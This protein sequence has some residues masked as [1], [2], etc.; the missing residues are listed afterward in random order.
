[1]RFARWTGFVLSL[2]C[3]AL[4]VGADELS[5]AFALPAPEFSPVPIWWWS[6]DK[7]DEARLRE[8][9]HQLARGGIHNAIILN[10]APSGPLYGSAQDDPP[11]LT[12][13]WWKLFAAAVDE[14]KNAGVRIWFYDQ[15][16]FSGSNLQA[17]LV[18]D[19]PVYRGVNLERVIADGSGELRVEIPP[20]AE[21][22]AAFTAKIVQPEIPS[23]SWIWDKT[24]P[25]AVNSRFFRKAVDVPAGAKSLK[26][27]VTGDNGYVAWFNGVKLG[28]EC[29]YDSEGWSEAEEFDV[30]PHLRPN[31]NVLAVEGRNL[32]G[33]G[34]I[35]VEVRGV[36]AGGAEFVV[37]SDASFKMS[38][39]APEGWTSP[40]YD[41]VTW[42]SADVMGPVNMAPYGGVEGMQSNNIGPMGVQ[43]AEVKALP[44]KV[45]NG[46][47]TA[48]V[49]DG[50]NRLM[51]YYTVPGGFD[52]QNPDAG[53][54]LISVVHG[55][56][57]KRFPSELGKTIAGSFQDEFP[58]LPR[59]SRLMPEKF[60]ERCV[61][62]LIEYLPALHDEVVD[63]FGNPTGPT[64]AQIR[65]DAAR[66]AAELCEEAFFIPLNKWHE[67]FNMLCGYDQTVRNADPI[68]GERYYVDYFKT[69]RHY[70]VPGNDM[71]GDIKPHQAI[72]ELYKRP[73]VW[74]EGFHSS[75]WGQT[76]EDI[77]TILHPW[78]AW[79]ATLFNPHAIYYSIHGSYWEWAPPD[80]GWR[81]PYYIHYPLLADYSARLSAVLAKGSLITDIAV[82][83]PASTV[84][85]FTGFGEPGAPANQAQRWYWEVQDELT[86]D[87]RDFT[88]LDED[89]LEKAV[90]VKG[91]LFAGRTHVGAVILPNAVALNGKS[92]QQLNRLL[93]TGGLVIVCGDK[94]QWLADH[95]LADTEFAAALEKLMVRVVR[96]S[97][98][99]DLT[100]V[101]RDRVPRDIQEPL[102]A[103]HRSIADRDFYFV[104]S[105]DETKANGRARYD[106]NTRKLW[107]TPAAQGQRLSFTANVDGVPE[108][109]DAATGAITRLNYT[110][111]S[112]KTKVTVSLETTP[113][114]LVSFRA[115]T[116]LD[117]LAVESDLDITK[118][119]WAADAPVVHGVPP[120][121]AEAQAATSHVARIALAA[122]VYEGSAPAT[123]VSPVEIAGPF[124]SR[125]VR[126][127]DNEDGSFAWP[128]SDGLLPVEMRSFKGMEESSPAAAEAFR[129]PDFD[130]AQWPKVL[131]SFGPRASVAG[132][133]D[134]PFDAA[135]P[136]APAAD[137]F[138]PAEYSLKLGINE[139]PVFRAALGG[140][141]RIPEDFI[142]LG[143]AQPG[144]TYLVRADVRVPGDAPVNAVLRVGAIA[145]KR[146]FMNGSEVVF[147]SPEGKRTLRASVTLKPGANRLEILLQHAGNLRLFYQF[148]PEGAAPPEAEWIWSSEPDN[149]GSTRFVRTFDV[150]GEVKTAR[151][152]VAL[153]DMHRISVNGKKVAD[154]GNFDA[155]F[156]SR[157][158]NYDIKPFLVEGT[159]TLEIDAHDTGAP[160]GLLLDGLVELADG[161]KVAFA[162][163]DTFTTGSGRPVR[164]VAGAAHGYMGDPALLLLYPRP[165][166]LPEAGWL[167]DEPARPAPFSQFVYSMPDAAPKPFWF[168]FL[169]PPGADRIHLRAAGKASL[170]VNGAETPCT[171][172]ADGACV[173]ELP[174]AKDLRRVAA[175]RIEALPGFERGA[176]LLAPVTF[177]VGEGSL[178]C[179][180]WDEAGLPH[181]SG[182][183]AYSV[184]FDL[185]ELPKEG[186]RVV[187]DLGRVRG[188]ADVTVNGKPCG[189]R[190]WHPYRFDIAAAAQAGANR[191]VI[192][193]FNTLG[194][195]FADGHPGGHVYDNHTKSGLFGPVRVQP[196]EPVTIPLAQKQ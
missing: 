188:S 126:T 159:N 14:G 25:E 60:R 7:I 141:G 121:N 29:T 193:V 71:D 139:D 58:A 105:D 22:V 49:G 86:R 23:A 33:K 13:D 68:R 84:H 20:L 95:S 186:G 90:V 94:P 34:G 32:G 26:V 79:G 56:M 39:E 144:K 82:L 28:E 124:A 97:T 118:I 47:M 18:R 46:T 104:M 143:D 181:Y 54:A 64:T 155:Y 196:L 166:P 177:D 48:Q 61:Y 17:R 57:E 157:A 137:A 169:L 96:I 9:I 173:A 163:G 98:P 116:A 111:E 119:D 78:M 4:T 65:C 92:V 153:G 150:Q 113:A 123:P 189:A 110:R 128:P 180:S 100:A 52:Y 161:G 130:D 120:M 5:D 140:K 133:L 31:G 91:R 75:G 152:V 167:A 102:R 164:I 67:K 73:R 127:C 36:D 176:A 16:G 151:M 8:Q 38:A 77:V 11:F 80:T 168:R 66:V 183:I 132:P 103:M 76:L 108:F 93:D 195:H 2:V 99:A 112:G 44:L 175:L 30:T 21:P 170:F 156:M 55:Q 174:G 138:R 19:N 165:H 190:A 129:S 10:L 1:M 88:I 50:R 194:P 148:L 187:L 62:N 12:E 182:G 37:L 136:P 122:A 185:A 171:P 145:R 160:T 45:V 83:H 89:S 6:G 147:A 63:R 40:D 172:E 107:E 53:A 85:A 59:Y 135:T 35:A 146:V 162:S 114:P 192:R 149:P 74:I 41:D 24:A 51:L 179:G 69:M 15:L 42:R 101:L 131:A 158:E 109:W 70:S 142:D 43:I 72:A 125:L 87:Y 117:P 178:A 115:P 3:S 27:I 184:V 134:D 81:Q 154:Q 106:V 191:V